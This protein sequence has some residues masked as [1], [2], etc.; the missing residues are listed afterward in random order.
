M[1][2]AADHPARGALRAGERGRWP[3]PTGPT[4]SSGCASRCPARASTACSAPPDILEDLLLLGALEDKVVI[5][6]MNRGGLAGHGVR[7][8]RPVHR[9]RRRRDRAGWASRAARC[10][11][12]STPTTRRR[13]RTLEACADAVSDLAGARADGDGRAVHL[14]PRR[15]PGPQRP[16]RRGRDPRPSTIAAGL[17]TTSAYTWLK[18]P[19]V[20]DM[21]R[22][23][24]ATTLPALLLGGEVAADQDA[25]FAAWQQGAGAAQVRGLVVGRSL[26][27][28]PDDDVAARRRH[29]G[30]AAV[31]AAT[32]TLSNDRHLRPV[33]GHRAARAR[34]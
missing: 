12:A 19:V 21:E 30:R 22:V 7:A 23:L 18:V 8:R 27:Y 1:I 11:S 16:V 32:T 15:R 9:L 29:R 34:R 2:V 6:S 25:A 24:A 33:D 20:D 26:L 10:C 3:W 31:M 17:G 4:C 13:S 28:P 5:G 14:P